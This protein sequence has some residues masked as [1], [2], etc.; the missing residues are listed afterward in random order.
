MDT[1]PGRPIA[2][3]AIGV[4]DSTDGT[5][6]FRGALLTASNLIP[7]PKSR[8][9]LFPR[10]AAKSLTAFAGF[11]SPAQV[12]GLLQIGNIVYG[13]IAE[14]GGAFSG[15][16]V[17]FSYN[18]LTG[19]FDTIAMPQGAAAL[20]ATP[21]AVGDWTPPIMGVVGQRIVITHPGY[22]GAGSGF[23]FGWLDISGFSDATVTGSTHSN[24]T[25][26][27]L[28]KNALNSGWQVGM[29]IAGGTIPA[30][31]VITAINVSALDLNTTGIFNGTAVITG[32]SSLTGV[33]PGSFVFVG[34][35]QAGIVKSVD[36]PTQVTLTAQSSLNTAGS[37][38]GINFSG[39][40]TITISRPA[41]GTASGVTLTVAGGTSSAP[42]YAAGNTNT[43]PLPSVPVAVAQ[44]NG[45]AYFACPGNGM[46]FS[47][48][49][50]PC[51]QTFASQGLN[52]QNGLDITAFGTI[53]LAQVFGGTLQAL[54]AFQGD[55]GMQQVSGDVAT[56][57]LQMNAISLGVG[58]LSPLTICST[59]QGLAF[60]APDGLRILS[61]S[62][63]VSDPIGSSGDGVCYP[64][65]STVFPTRQCAA[66]NQNVMRISTQNGNVSGQ[67][68]QE[69]W[70]DFKLKIWTGP[71]TFPAAQIVAFQGATNHGFTIA[72]VG[73]AARLFSSAVNPSLSDT[74]VENGAQLGFDYQTTLLPDNMDMSM[75]KMVIANLLCAISRNESW[76]VAVLDE[77]DQV[78]QVPSPNGGISAQALLQGPIVSDT[79]W[80]S[81]IW[82][83]VPWG[84]GGTSLSQKA[85]DLPAPVL[86]KQASVQISGNCALGTI[87]GN[88]YLQIEDLGYPAVAPEVPSFTSASGAYALKIGSGAIGTGATGGTPPPT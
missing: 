22:A 73:V 18:L 31:A 61:F 68:F 11:T 54:I 53:G 13:M 2:W 74:Y 43:N 27:T 26:D 29:S 62:G 87:I 64:F 58:T 46:K 17:P 57:N 25:V 47:D 78:I 34:G 67:P 30:N 65:I 69:W 45:R 32:I 77:M 20:P 33:V 38:I 44:F 4:T 6:T 21:A 37:T 80:G 28:S 36:S 88:L 16:D 63:Q 19:A 49:L 51:Q 24:T 23:F 66:F 14:T 70:Y 10:P 39:G 59:T 76:T 86:F 48:A 40:T 55:T 75:N 81:F 35:L 83:K 8:G 9:N 71:H 5:N 15:L 56:S 42:L 3:P 72:P 79:I 82:G 1:L 50:S 41:G 60:V 84:G 12:N 7:S 52:P 85:I